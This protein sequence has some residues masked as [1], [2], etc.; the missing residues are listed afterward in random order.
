MHSSSVVFFIARQRAARLP[1]YFNETVMSREKFLDF[2]FHVFFRHKTCYFRE[3]LVV[4][5]KEAENLKNSASR[6]ARGLKIFFFG[7]YCG[8]DDKNFNNIVSLP[9]LLLRKSL[10]AR[11]FPIANAEDDFRLLPFNYKLK[12]EARRADENHFTARG[13]WF[14]DEVDPNRSSAKC[15]SG[16]MWKC[17]INFARFLPASKLISDLADNLA[18]PPR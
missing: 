7:F 12:D 14:I 16:G 15:L 11:S 9:I 1:R 13:F 8:R 3:L 10:V 2:L 18:S 4:L 5:Q 17:Q 6:W